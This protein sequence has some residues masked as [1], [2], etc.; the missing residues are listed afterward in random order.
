MCPVLCQD[1]GIYVRGVCQCHEGWKGKECD[2]P[3][4]QCEIP[5]C[6]AN[7]VCVDGL[8]VCAT[9]FS[10]QNCEVGK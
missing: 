3:R 10:G 5:N 9:G 2:I 7:G 1:N 6:N 4:H 8:C